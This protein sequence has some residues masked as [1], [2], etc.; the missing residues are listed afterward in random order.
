MIACVVLMLARRDPSSANR[1]YP[2][3]I[4]AMIYESFRDT[5]DG[6]RY[7]SS[8]TAPFAIREIEPL[9]GGRLY[10]RIVFLDIRLLMPFYSRLRRE[11]H[12]RLGAFHYRVE[13]ICMHPE[14]H[15][16]AGIVGFHDLHRS[17][18]AK[19]WRLTFAFT[20]FKHNDM[21]I[22]F[23]LPYHLVRSLHA[24]WAA[25][26][27]PPAEPPPG[28]KECVTAL[29]SGLIVSSHRIGTSIYKV[30]PDLDLTTFSGRVTVENNHADPSSRELLNALLSLSPYAGTGWKCAYGMGRVNAV[31][32]G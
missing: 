10:V 26:I 15:P 31:A 22:L 4:H 30:R 14:D 18:G 21:S 16:E 19:K 5:P 17:G 20:A 24:K 32:I 1:V 7:H 3:Y 11:K 2:N 25:F 9:A 23:P 12:I 6:A 27:R 8:G 28:M 29:A 13:K